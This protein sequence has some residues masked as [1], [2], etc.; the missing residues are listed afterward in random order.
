MEDENNQL[1]FLNVLVCRN[2]YGGLKTKLFRK[3]TNVTQVLSFNSNHPISHKLSTCVTLYRRVKTHCNE[4]EDKVAGVQ[5][6]RWTPTVASDMGFASRTELTDTFSTVG[7]FRPQPVCLQLQLMTCSSRTTAPL[8][9]WR[10]RTGKGA[11][12]SSPKAAPILD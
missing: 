9:L 6:R 10:K 11:W 5:Y 3:A 12:T 1:A 4:M 7:V 2:D 8:T